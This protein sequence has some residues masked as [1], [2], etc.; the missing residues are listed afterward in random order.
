ML[1]ASK[2][3]HT[4]VGLVA[5]AMAVACSKPSVARAPEP[6][7]AQPQVHSATAAEQ[8]LPEDPV[9]AKRS[10][11]QW[12]QHMEDEEHERQQG[13]DRQHLEQHRAVVSLIGAARARY[14]RA[15][16]AA[17]V[18]KARAEMPQRIAELRRRITEIDHWGVNSRLLGD[19]AALETSLTAA[20]ADAKLAALSGDSRTLEEVRTA[21][22]QHLKTIGDWLEEAAES[23]DE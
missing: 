22:D 1:A 12:R 10:E 15:K 23:E 8:R 9:A 7:V 16:T 11:A 2:L 20:Y 14:D 21:F 5:I 17:A 3:C 19:Y 18:A 13:F 4:G 6:R